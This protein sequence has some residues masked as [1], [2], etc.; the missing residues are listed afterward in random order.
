M[1]SV[2]YMKR[3]RPAKF[4]VPFKSGQK[5]KYFDLF[6]MPLYIIFSMFYTV[7]CR[8]GQYFRDMKIHI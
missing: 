4:G 6:H 5:N 8:D 2:L 7:M 3:T 1:F